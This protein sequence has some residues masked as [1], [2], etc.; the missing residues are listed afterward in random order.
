MAMTLCDT[1][2]IIEIYRGNQ[3]IKNELDNIGQANITLSDISCAELF[4]GA[5]NKTELQKIIND[6]RLLNTLPINREISNKGVR[7]VQDY[8]LSHKMT[9]EDALIAATALYH[10]IELFTLNLKD[11]MYIPE[12]KLYHFPHPTIA[13]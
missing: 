4:Y 6:I 2:I 5:K 10:D 7:L 12:I 13:D 11:F 9:I 3:A 8:C 1:N